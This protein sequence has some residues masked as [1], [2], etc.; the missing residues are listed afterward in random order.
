MVCRTLLASSLRKKKYYKEAIRIEVKPSGAPSNSKE[1]WQKE[2]LQWDP[3]SSG[4]D[5]LLLDDLAKSFSSSYNAS[6]TTKAIDFASVIDSIPSHGFQVKDLLSAKNSVHSFSDN[7]DNFLPV[8]EEVNKSTSVL[9]NLNELPTMLDVCP[10]AEEE[11]YDPIRHQASSIENLTPKSFRSEHPKAFK[12]VDEER[13]A[14][15]SKTKSELESVNYSDENCTH[16]EANAQE[17][18]S[19]RCISS[20]ALDDVIPDKNEKT[21]T[22]LADAKLQE[23]QNSDCELKSL[24]GSMEVDFP[25]PVYVKHMNESGS[26]ANSNAQIDKMLDTLLKEDTKIGEL[27]VMEMDNSVPENLTGDEQ[28]NKHESEIAELG[29]MPQQTS[30]QIQIEDDSSIATHTTEV[31]VEDLKHAIVCTGSH[32]FARI[33][34]VSGTLPLTYSFVCFLD[35]ISLCDLAI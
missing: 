33:Q 14:P 30:H 16:L 24:N 3:I 27:T 4:E 6:N 10:E 21:D 12:L 35:Y 13:E 17:Y 25:T 28:C 19:D 1:A 8:T 2:L 20:S 29:E 31:I 26:Y 5:D 7:N 9:K 23:A 34:S 32:Q 11:L 22:S 15:T 18:R